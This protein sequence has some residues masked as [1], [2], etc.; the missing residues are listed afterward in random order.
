MSAPISRRHSFRM[1]LPLSVLRPWAAVLKSAL[2]SIALLFSMALFCSTSLAQ[3]QPTVGVIPGFSSVE[4]HE[5]DTINLANLGIKLNVPVRSKAG[6]IPFSFSLRGDV[7]V[8]KTVSI[9]PGGGQ[10]V[11]FYALPSLT[12]QENHIGRLTGPKAAFQNSGVCG[13]SGY[14]YYDWFYTDADAANHGAGIGPLYSCGPTSGSAYST[15]GSG[16]YVFA[17]VNGSGYAIDLRGNT[18]SPGSFS[19]PNGNSIVQ[20]NVTGTTVYNYT[21]TLGQLAMT[22]TFNTGGSPAE[23]DVWT[24]ALA[25]NQSVN[26]YTTPLTLNTTFGCTWNANTPVTWNFPSSLSFPDGSTLSYTWEQVYNNNTQ[27]TGRLKSITLPTGGKITYAYSGGT[28]GVDCVGGAPAVMSRTTPDGIWT[29][30]RVGSPGT[31]VTDPSG[32]NVVYTFVYAS[33]PAMAYSGGDPLETKKQ[34]YNGSIT[35]ANLIQTVITCYNNPSSTPTNCNPTGLS[36]PITEKD[37]YTTYPNVT[38]YSAVK[39]TFDSYGRITDIKTFD[40]NVTTPTNEEQIQYGNG[41]PSSQTCTPISTYIIGRPCSVTLLDSQHGNAIL[42]QAWNAYD[43]YGNLVQTWNLVSGSGAT[44]SYLSKQY[45]YNSHGV[46]QTMTD[47]N[48]Q[49]MNYTTTSCNN[50][51]ATSQVPT[52]F[53]N[54]RTSQTWD[55]NGGVVTSST[56]AD[57]QTTHDDFYVGAATD[58]FYRPLDTKDELGNVTNFA[59]TP[60]ST[61]STFSFNGGVSVIDAVSTTDSIGRPVT[62]QLKQDPTSQNFDTRSRTFDSDGRPYQT[63][64]PCV[65]TAKGTGCGAS[66]ETQTYDALNRPLVHTGPGG[67]VV[68]KTYPANDVKTTLTPAPANENAKAVQKEY[69]GLGRL[70]STC[71]I[72]SVAGSGP[73]GQ[74]NGGTG[75]LTSYA[76]DAAGRLLQTVENAQVSSP[77][78]VRSYTYDK[79]GRML[80][81]TNPEWTSGSTPQTVTYTYDSADVNPGCPTPTGMSLYSSGDL[82]AKMDPKGNVTCYFYDGLHRSVAITYGGPDS[83]NGQNKFFFYDAA[84]VNGIAMTNAQGRLAEA[85]TCP[86]VIL[87]C[88]SII[89]DEGYSY[90]ARGLLSDYYQKSSHSSGYYHLSATHWEDKQVK[91]VTGVGLPTITFGASDGSGLDGEGRITKVTASNGT[92]PVSGVT[93]NNGSYTTEPIG[94]LLTVTLGAGDT[95]NFTY[96]KNTGRMTSHSA[97]V[98]AAPTVLT[99]SL[100]WNANGTLQQLSITDGYNSADTQVCTYLYDDF[101]RVAGTTGSNPIPGVNCVNGS[102]KIWNQTFTYGSDAFGNVTKSSSGPGLSWNPGYS[103]STNHYTLAGTSYDNNGNLLNDTFHTYAWLADG[104][105]ATIDTNTITYDANGNKVEENVGGTIHEYVS[106]F[107]VSA[108]MTGT[109][110]KATTIDLPGGVQALYSGGILQRFRFPDWQGTIRAESNPTTRVFTESLA[111]APFGERYAVKGAPFNVDSFTGKPDQ[112]VNDEYDFPAREE[113]NG[114]G[115]WV[116]PDPVRGTGNKYVYADNNPLSTVDIY[117]LYTVSMNGMDVS[118]NAE[119]LADGRN[120]LTESHQPTSKQTGGQTTSPSSGNGSSSAPTPTNQQQ[121]QTA[122]QQGQPAKQAQNPSHK[123]KSKPKPLVKGDAGRTIHPTKL[124]ASRSVYY[125]VVDANGNATREKHVI[126][127]SETFVDPPKHKVDIC[128]P[129]C[130]ESREGYVANGETRDDQGVVANDS[131]SVMKRFSVDGEAAQILN[132]KNV[133]FDYEILHNSN[134]TNPPFQSEYGNDHPK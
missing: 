103:S 71:L 130:V 11:F 114:Q 91:A 113:H 6:H 29:Y 30:S 49:V 78:Q 13:G 106:A 116:S 23:T 109:A 24:D 92:N 112:I 126:T 84:T 133:P 36:L 70:K 121:T 38:G 107:G 5:Y 41:N 100:S 128:S 120:E 77:Q 101:V 22:Q 3:Q 12:G 39:T 40:F 64:L 54:L 99:A 111:F 19:D 65:T 2:S 119:E 134:E 61:E 117:G 127:L 4:T 15:D 98:G 94:S 118:S 53:S 32:N 82:V 27:Y 35:S 9:R 8:T 33:T 123:H 46:V 57:S 95:Q 68:T 56:D 89:T 21:D 97:S 34:V 42:R 37:I 10:E 74:A 67:D 80:T 43:Q 31:T 110:E 86:G 1:V 129:P 108:Q 26:Y 45:T 132:D 124:A 66:T 85:Y 122:Q 18:L 87:P 104:H 79:L 60:T 72:S 25:N 20:T 81:E 47:V 59:Y 44:G 83:P 69:D 58:P 90:D 76:Y 88:T 125:Y 73:C 48:G 16:L 50:M 102:T 55:C 63:S 75:F 62:S 17:N 14:Q 131:F 105:V 51:F 115:R 52:N 93:Y 28:N 96:D 7:Q